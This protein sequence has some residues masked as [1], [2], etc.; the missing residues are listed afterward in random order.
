MNKG[1]LQTPLFVILTALCFVL[2]TKLEIFGIRPAL[3]L[4]PVYYVGLRH[5]AFKGALFGALIGAIADSLAGNL[6]GPNM[7]AMGTA[8]I[9]ASSI[10]GGF[11]RWTP[12]LGVIGLFVITWADGIVSY[13]ALSVFAEAPTTVYNALMIMLAQ[14]TMN[15]VAGLF[16]RPTDEH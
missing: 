3:T 6:L 11:L 16:I 15:A 4:I 12:I 10:T 5:G 8:G 2:E 1:K 13:V 14:A 9:L 7:L